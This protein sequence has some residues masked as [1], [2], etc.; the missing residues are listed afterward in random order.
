MLAG[1]KGGDREKRLREANPGPRPIGSMS[2]LSPKM[3]GQMAKKMNFLDVAS[4]RVFSPGK[5]G[6]DISRE[7]ENKELTEICHDQA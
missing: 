5:I 7:L 1:W 4:R 2:V 6:D 3:I